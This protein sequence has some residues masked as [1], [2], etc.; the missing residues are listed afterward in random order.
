[1]FIEFL[2]ELN[3]PKKMKN[4]R[5]ARLPSNCPAGCHKQLTSSQWSC[6]WQLKL[7]QNNFW[8]VCGRTGLLENSRIS[9]EGFAFTRPFVSLAPCAGGG[10]GQACLGE[11]HFQPSLE[12]TYQ[13]RL[14]RGGCSAGDGC[15]QSCR[16]FEAAEGARS[17]SASSPGGNLWEVSFSSRQLGQSQWGADQMSQ[18]CRTSHSQS[19]NPWFPASWGCRGCLWN[20]ETDDRVIISWHFGWTTPLSSWIQDVSSAG[21]NIFTLSIFQEICL[22]NKQ[23]AQAFD[24]LLQASQVKITYLLQ[25]KETLERMGGR[26][27]QGQCSSHHFKWAG[28]LL[29]EMLCCVSLPQNIVWPRD[30]GKTSRPFGTPWT[31]ESG[32]TNLLEKMNSHCMFWNQALERGGSW[33]GFWISLLKNSML[34]FW[35]SGAL[36]LDH[37]WAILFFPIHTIF[38]NDAIYRDIFLALNWSQMCVISSKICFRSAY[39]EIFAVCFWENNEM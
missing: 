4:E 36:T 8:T 33:S 28:H 9:W 7:K 38:Q 22:E 11:K 35:S 31:G 23:S 5:G 25:L 17:S 20:E 39:V 21:A 29:T 15:D 30:E 10:L 13:R 37:P 34:H 18:P 27:C 16:H 19:I 12:Q 2:A 3:P 32:F 1:M 24:T 6:G 26:C 14:I